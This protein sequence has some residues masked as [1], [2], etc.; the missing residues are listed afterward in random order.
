M[1]RSRSLGRRLGRA[2]VGAAF[3]LALTVSAAPVRAAPAGAVDGGPCIT[4][5]AHGYRYIAFARSGVAEPGIYLATNRSGTWRLSPHPVTSGDRCAAI[6]VDTSN[7]VHLLATRPLPADPN[8]NYDLYY[9]TNKSGAWRASKVHYGEVGVASLAIDRTGRANIAI[10]D[11]DGVF[12]FR[13]A[14]DGGWLNP[15]A[16]GGVASHLRVDPAGTLWLVVR[17]VSHRRFVRLMNRSGAWTVTRIPLPSS[18]AI[19]FD[20][21]IDGLGRRSIASYDGNTGYAS[22]YRDAGSS[23]PRVD[24]TQAHPGRMLDEAVSE[25]GG[26]LHLMFGFFR[27]PDASGVVDQNR[28]A[29]RWQTQLVGYVSGYR[30]DMDVDRRGRVGATF[31]RDG[32]IWSYWNDWSGPPHRFRVSDLG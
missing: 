2:S 29:G 15:Y 19:S 8:G 17:D 4:F 27:P 31:E 32:V 30:A 23:W 20:L 11:E 18:N 28:H 26:S 5:D 16:T 9:A 6:T 24:R 22:I 1:A 13:R 12:M 25:P 3:A 21:A 7:H 14:A 10:T